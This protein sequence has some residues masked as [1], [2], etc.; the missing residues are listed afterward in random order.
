MKKKM[1]MLTLACMLCFGSSLTVCAAEKTDS[2]AVVL[3]NESTP[4]NTK[5]TKKQMA[6]IKEL[7][8]AKEYAEMY[9]DVVKALG[10][11]EEALWNHFVT[12][13]FSEGRSLSKDFNVFAYASSYPDLQAAFGDD[14]ASYYMH[15]I[16]FGK[17]EK[18]PLIT[19]E[20]A[21][22]A[23]VVVYGVKGIAIGKNTPVTEKDKA[24]AKSYRRPSEVMTKK[25]TATTTTT[26]TKT[27]AKNSTSDDKKKPT[28]PSSP[29]VVKPDPTPDVPH[30]HTYVVK[31]ITNKDG[32]DYHAYVCTEDG[33]VKPSAVAE[34]NGLIECS[35]KAVSVGE[36]KHNYVCTECKHVK[37]ISGTETTEACVDTDNDGK[38]DKC[39]ADIKTTE[40]EECKHEH[41]TYTVNSDGTHTKH[42]TDCDKDIEEATAHNWGIVQC[43]VNEDAQN[44][45]DKYKHEWVCTECGTK[46]E[47]RGSESCDFDDETHACKVCDR[48]VEDTSSGTESGGQDGTDVKNPDSSEGETKD[49]VD[50]GDNSDTSGSTSENPDSSTPSGTTSSSDTGEQETNPS[51]TENQSVE[52]LV[53]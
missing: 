44:N 5:A 42:C 47:S 4:Y 53:E 6:A 28:K 12:Y 18:R 49:N 25:S 41:A 51:P 16:N 10:T 30:E 50:K 17:T 43:P 7:F 23:G 38:C 37:T 19:I 39:D 46:D 3:E 8:N 9:P 21:E 22:K 34:D 33:V 2:T 11:S 26:S 29:T 45:S 52:N 20:K 1:I 14:L 32:V 36:N 24:S 13:G 35:Y 15:Y 48:V 31:Y 27:T 40:P